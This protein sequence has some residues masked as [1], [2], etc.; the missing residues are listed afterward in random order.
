MPAAVP[1][2]GNVGAAG[3]DRALDPIAGHVLLGLAQGYGADQPNPRMLARASDLSRVAE[4]GDD[5]AVALERL[6][7]LVARFP[8]CERLQVLA[9]RL[10]ETA[11]VEVDACVVWAG[12]Q[13]RFP[14]SVEA[15]RLLLR[16]TARVRGRDAALKLM[17]ARFPLPPATAGDLLVYAWG[18]DELKIFDRA[19][20]AFEALLAADDRH[21]SA[22]I[23]FSKSL[24]NRGEIWR[25]F[26]ILDSARK[27]QGSSPKL[28][29][30]L[31]PIEAK[32]QHL[33]VLS[34][35][36][37]EGRASDI[38][39]SDIFEDLVRHPTP[40]PERRSFVGSVLMI[41]GS[42]GAGGAERQFS[43]T[44]SALQ[45]AIQAGEPMAGYDV[46]GPLN[47]FCRSL[48]SREAA[49]FFEADLR[50]RSIPIYEYADFEAF[51]GHEGQSV[52]APIRAALDFL[53]QQIVDGTT[54]L[55]DSIRHLAPDV[56]HIWQDGSILAAGL[57]A[58]MA[59]VPRIVLTVR[60]LPPI[61]RPERYRPEYEV[62]FKSLLAL[63]SV[64]LVANSNTAA[65]RY[66]EWLELEP[67]RVD[68]IYNGVDALSG[69]AGPEDLAKASAF[70]AATAGWCFTVGSVMRF[71]ENKR[72]FLWLDAAAALLQSQ[73]GMRFILVGDGPLKAAASDYA[74][75]LGIAGRV[76]FTGRSQ[77]VGYWL[78][79]MDA[80]AL[81]SAVEGLP[82][83]L[84]EAQHAGVPVITTPAG[85]AGETVIDG[86]TGFVL[87]LIDGEP[88]PQDVADLVLALHADPQRRAEMSARARNWAQSTFSVSA[89]TE[90]MA[91]TFVD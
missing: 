64:R 39:L 37:S 24:F 10:I 15:L 3:T 42:L 89:M 83:V 19:D 76:I 80:F 81:L 51:G 55:A 63:P 70:D 40:Q 62:V 46:I 13:Q 9:A 69:G 35:R 75:R 88:D 6:L 45:N 78:G 66:E 32:L 41:I 43:V 91:R 52:V 31:A 77:A 57:A 87:P 48:K 34:P 2:V 85:G 26:R 25:A 53:P 50:S 65:R 67:G 22:S 56:V 60:S 90:R 72:P 68:V 54:R 44:A 14:S 58:A 11:A 18:W 38:V 28:A 73:P 86:E 17:E 82:N 29:K 30:A 16:W 59:R 74:A 27:S 7:A 23:A 4:A 12:V 33:R 79:R 8:S 20:Q 5:Q 61:D 49:N 21:G 1:S 71:D 36:F 47:V 84:I